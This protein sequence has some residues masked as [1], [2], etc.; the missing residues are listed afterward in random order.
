M[1]LGFG[2]IQGYG[3]TE[4]TS[5]ISVNHPLKLGKGSVG[6]IIPG[7]QVKLAP[8]GEILVRGENVASG[9]W[10]AGEE[11]PAVEA[12]EGGPGWFHTGDLGELDAEGNLYFKGRKKNVIVTPAGMNVHPEDLEAALRRQPE[13]R[14]CVVLGLERDGNAEPCAVLMLHDAARDPEPIVERANE[15]LAEYQRMR[16]WMIWPEQDFPRTGTQKPR[17]NL[18][19]EA[20]AAQLGEKR[21]APAERARE[22]GGLAE[23]IAR[24]TSRAPEALAPD[25]KLETDLNLSSLD[26]VELMSAIED[27]YQI[28]LNETRFA[29][30]TT[31]G[32]LERLL[33]QSAPRR[34][35][36][37]YPAWA[38][39]WP[40][41]WIRLL[42]YYLLAWPAT[43]LLGSP[44]IRG[45]AN[46][47]G[48]RGPVLV[49][50][51][52]TVYFD[53]AFVLAALPMRLRH[54]LA[55]AMGGE[56]LR[57]MRHP[58]EEMNLIVRWVNQLGYALAVVLF[59]VFP[60]P[61]HSGF[62]ESFQFAGESVDRGYSVLVFPEG[63]VAR[64]GK[65]ARFR[66]GIGLLANRLSLPVVPLRIDGLFE[67]KQRKKRNARFGQIRVT[68]GAP[69]KFPGDADPEQI[70]R[71]L[72]AWVAKLEDRAESE[73][74]KR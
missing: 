50:A 51:N 16:R 17:I 46:L 39:Q 64:D 38:Q 52:H 42:V 35:E 3:L 8:N 31:V 28:D 20:V 15:S 2:V 65:L 9:Y 45:R 5:L 43:W 68:L 44:R 4:T 47:R 37:H 58:P 19:A 26:R 36:Y 67:L 71:E 66:S 6:R 61:Q 7:Q 33:R 56:R 30:A 60:L 13:V 69:V 29:A 10:Q 70:T 73:R 40:I 41:T 1:R 27:R 22:K 55:V 72:E 57:S 11:K 74:D 32:E 59:N 24:I 54:R 21:G 12:A 14:D 63:E 18:I 62:R 53:V 34:S 48:M 23:L 25:A 49:I